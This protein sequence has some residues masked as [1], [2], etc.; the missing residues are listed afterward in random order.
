MFEPMYLSA[1]HSDHDVALA[2]DL[3]EGAARRSLG[4]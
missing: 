1:A 3:V 2:L 4:R